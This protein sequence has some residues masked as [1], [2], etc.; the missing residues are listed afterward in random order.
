MT[1]VRLDKSQLKKMAACN[2]RVPNYT[3]SDLKAGVVHLG[4]GA[5]HRAH[6]AYYFDELAR[7]G[8]TDWGICELSLRSTTVQ[9]ELTPQDYLYT[10]AIKDIK[11]EYQ[12]IGSIIDVKTATL[13]RD[14]ALDQMAD[15]DTR[16]VSMTITEK[17]YCLTPQ[18]EL[19]CDNDL[20]KHDLNSPHSPVTAIGCLVEAL[21]R[22]MQRGLK[23][24]TLLS[25]DNLVQNGDRL[26]TA[27]IQYARLVNQSLA[28]WIEREATFPNTMVDSIT[29]ATTDDLRV[30]VQ[31]ET[32]CMDATPIQRE[33]FTQ[34]VI[35]DRFCNGRPPLDRVGV[36]FTDKVAPYE[37]AKL[38]I[39]NGLHSSLAFV[40]YLKGYKTVYEAMQ[41]AQLVGFLNRTALNEILPT[42]ELDNQESYL[43]SILE[44]FLNPAIEYQ[45]LQIAGDSSQKVP[46]RILGTL[47]DNLGTD[48]LGHRGLVIAIAAWMHYVR[49][50]VAKQ[51]SL[52]D[53]L[54]SSLKTIAASCNGQGD[55]DVPLFLA[56]RQMFS[57]QLVGDKQFV[58]LLTDM[59]NQIEAGQLSQ[60]LN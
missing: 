32:G 56:I 21:H 18:G 8:E 36:T 43:D 30:Q 17:G 42:L 9:D 3:R 50:Q 1:Q 16:I 35:E 40:G 15:A 33:S 60:L 31:R 53:P 39:L 23:P 58:D 57:A 28:A 6:Q 2:I 37:Q 45:L 44:R 52:N 14:A 27:V 22:R 51:A 46:F 12:V 5:F 20:I 47:A 54:E 7:L 4:P 10:L 48:R 24:F 49:K 38:R 29:P 26:S 25:C 19:D 41:D 13:D 55:H 34:W 59:Y 11:S